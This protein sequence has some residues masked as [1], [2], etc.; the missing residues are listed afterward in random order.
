LWWKEPALP[1]VTSQ[2]LEMA[3]LKALAHDTEQLILRYRGALGR[4]EGVEYHFTE[5][6]KIVQKMQKAMKRAPFTIVH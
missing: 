6:L 4:M 1:V 3:T 2:D 5:A